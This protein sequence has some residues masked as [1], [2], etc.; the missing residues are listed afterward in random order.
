MKNQ[1]DEIFI[2]ES[3]VNALT[4]QNC[5]AG[6]RGSFEHGFVG[7]FGCTDQPES[8]RH[9]ID[10]LDF[11]D[12]DATLPTRKLSLRR[13]RPPWGIAPV[14]ADVDERTLTENQMAQSL[15]N[16]QTDR[17][18]NHDFELGDRVGKFLQN[19]SCGRNV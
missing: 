1:L 18:Y 15:R 10:W 4:W 11:A 17:R 12:F 2:A 8:R 14:A 9:L 5:V 13:F 16:L 3:L 7:D 6:A 19:C